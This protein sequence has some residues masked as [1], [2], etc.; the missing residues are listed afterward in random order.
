MESRSSYETLPETVRSFLESN[1]PV[2]K[3]DSSERPGLTAPPIFRERHLDAR[4]MLKK[5]QVLPLER[6][7]S[8]ALDL[9]LESVAKRNIELPK[10][11]KGG[12]VNQQEDEDSFEFPPLA[13]TAVML[14][15]L[16]EETTALHPCSLASTLLF[17]PRARQW[18][19]AC[20]EWREIEFGTKHSPAALCGHGLA[21]RSFKFM[22][23]QE[24]EMLDD[25]TR[26]LM[27]IL[28]RRRPLAWWQLFSPGEEAR[29]LLADLDRIASV[30]SID[31]GRCHTYG[32]KSPPPGTFSL[33]IDAL[34]TPWG[35]S[36]S[37]LSVESTDFTPRMNDGL[38]TKVNTT[39]TSHR[40]LR[41]RD[42]QPRYTN[43]KQTTPTLL[44]MTDG[45][46]LSWP[47][48]QVSDRAADPMMDL[49]LLRAW[50]QSVEHD[51]TFIVFHCGNFERIGFRH[52]ESQTL[53]VSSLID[54]HNCSDPSYG[55]L[56]AGL[57]L[58]IVQDAINRTKRQDELDNAKPKSRKR[59]RDPSEEEPRKRYKTR[60][61][62]SKERAEA[63]ERD[64]DYEAVKLN[65]PKRSLALIEFRFGQYNS[66][67]PS[68][69]IRSGTK[70]KAT[71][72][73]DEYVSLVLTSKLGNGAVG[74][75]YDAQLE[76][77]ING[78]TRRARVAVKLG[79]KDDEIRSMRN[80]YSIYQHLASH[81]VV[82]GI[83]HIFGLYEDV[84][85]GTVALVMN[86]VGDSL[87]NL[88][89]DKTKRDLKVSEAAET[90]FIRILKN[91]HQAGI[92]HGDLGENNLMLLDDERATIIDFDRA[93]KNPTQDQK[94][95]EMRELIALFRYK[96]PLTLRW[97]DVLDD[98]DRGIERPHPTTQKDDD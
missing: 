60:F 7:L 97:G 56:Q 88:R 26:E 21:I 10:T 48:V 72:G 24:K 98:E 33:P 30:G 44:P 52:R 68:A 93:E 3:W 61:M 79:F 17:H 43:K 77:L 51:T 19:K 96:S 27:G 80:E 25:D 94:D 14:G 87:W 73:S 58:S 40:N 4:L 47:K 20:L 84:E 91:I 62:V 67:A 82:E 81:G 70:K 53:F 39:G 49:F 5:V 85:S 8:L 55:R 83:P 45:K 66:T 63:E 2:Q 32:C 65:A 38:P 9:T 18:S 78:Y 74:A 46:A 13:R 86:Y 37:S 15:L 92:W 34:T 54:V 89:P 35:T 69:L 31:A 95:A 23:D 28:Y 16:Y 59:R 11:V 22:S 75:V 12:I 36:T 41:K 90:A 50:A 64:K 6:F 29:S 57:Y 1:P 71:Y 42:K 76:I